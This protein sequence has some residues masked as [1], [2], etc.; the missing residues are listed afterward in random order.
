[1]KVI[2]TDADDPTTRNAE[3]AYKIVSQEPANTPMFY[4]KKDTGEIYTTSFTLD[5]EV[6]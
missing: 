3:I 2:A 5:R 1:M 6:S 4:L